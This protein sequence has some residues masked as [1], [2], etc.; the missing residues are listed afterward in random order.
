MSLAIPASASAATTFG[1]EVGSIFTGQQRGQIAPTAAINSLSGLYKAGGRVGRGDSNWA[2]TELK[3][4]V[5]GRHSYNW[6][7]DDMIVTDMAS[8]RLRWS[9][10]PFAP[11]LGGGPPLQRAPQA[12]RQ[13]HRLP[14]AASNATFA[15]YATR[16]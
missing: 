15:A 7:Y 6:T 16:S 5:H 9:R 2:I 1:A 11:T 8:A 3:A 10:R 14:A 4:P 13:G 12:V